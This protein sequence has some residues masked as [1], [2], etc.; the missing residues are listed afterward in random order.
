MEVSCAS[1][2]DERFDPK[3]VLTPNPKQFWVT[4]GLY[5][6]ELTFT[7]NQPKTINEVKFLATSV[8]RVVISGCP[9]LNG[10]SFKEIATTKDLGGKDGNSIQKESIRVAQPAAFQMI[11][12]II[13]DGWDDFASVHSIEFN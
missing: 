10:N 4:T 6:H 9:T 12:F 5:P 1:G 13:A 3:N 7:F 8:K 11:K 2:F